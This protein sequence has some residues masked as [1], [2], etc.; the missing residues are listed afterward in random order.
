V[1]A[2]VQ[3]SQQ[4]EKAKWISAEEAMQKLAITSKTTL[5][6]FRN[7]GRIKFTNQRRKCIYTM[8][9]QLMNILKRG[10]KAAFNLGSR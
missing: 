4:T 9:H 10:L 2:Y 1:L 7:E 5:K 3:V 6:Q 8:R